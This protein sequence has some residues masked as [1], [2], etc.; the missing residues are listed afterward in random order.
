M[1]GTCDVQVVLRCAYAVNDAAQIAYCN[2]QKGHKPGQS[3]LRSNNLIVLRLPA[4]RL[5]QHDVLSRFCFRRRFS[6]HPCCR[7]PR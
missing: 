7:H 5:Q 3:T 6:A 2:L 4:T 1:F